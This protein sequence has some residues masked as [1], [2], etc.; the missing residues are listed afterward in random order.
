MKKILLT[1]ISAVR[2]LR[3]VV[4]WAIA[5]QARAQAPEV[6]MHSGLPA[7]AGVSQI[8]HG[9]GIFIANLYG[10]FYSSSNGVDWTQ[11]AG[12]TLHGNWLKTPTLAFGAGKFVCVGDSG[13]IATSRDGQVWT[14]RSSGTTAYL[15]DVKFLHG[16][17]YI[18]G[19]SATFLQSRNGLRW[20]SVSIGKGSATDIYSTVDYG[21]GYFIVNSISPNS[22]VFRSGLD[23]LGN[24]T[25][26]TLTIA[27]MV[28]FLKRYFY[29]IADTYIATSTDAATWTKIPYFAS[30]TRRVS[31]GFYDSSNVYLVSSDYG[32]YAASY[33]Y[34]YPSP[35]GLNFSTPI[36][37][38]LHLRG[39]LYAR[40]HDY[41]FTDKGVLRSQDGV[42]YS[43]LGM[44]FQGVAFHK[45]VAVGVGYMGHWGLIRRTTDY[46]TWRDETPDSASPLTGCV[47]NGSRFVTSGT[48][49]ANNGG[50][51]DPAIVFASPH[52]VNWTS[53][54][55]S[56]IPLSSLTYGTGEG[57]GWYSALGGAG[58][59]SSTDAVSWTLTYA[60]GNIYV[61]KIRYVNGLFYAIGMQ[62]NNAYLP[63]LL[64]SYNG[65]AWGDISPNLPF[66]V[67]SLDDL[68]YDGS[69][70]IL[71]GTQLDSNDF[72]P[73]G[74]FSVK[75]ARVNNPDEWGD[76]GGISSPPAG[77]ILADPEGDQTFAYANGHYVGGAYA[78]KGRPE[79]YLLY[80]NDAVH[81]DYRPLGVNTGI[82]AIDTT[83]RSFH[84]VGVGNYWL[85]VDFARH[86]KHGS[87]D[88]SASLAAS[89][90][91][92]QDPRF[93]IYP[94][95]AAG[96]TTIVLPEQGAAALVL[97][98]VSG[99]A[100]MKKEFNDIRVTLPLALLPAGVYNLTV[101]QNGKLYTGEILHR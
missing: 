69:N 49:G 84:M 39:G 23:T 73:V 31:G 26:D 2:L 52:G 68:I 92:P 48:S 16:A 86:G 15:R 95:P 28:F 30:D 36:N 10:Y 88:S 47:Y 72:Y 7:N 58:I 4:F 83:G 8:V 44:N 22:V 65:A 51:I 21:N 79:S 34:V 50:V 24:W 94:N 77:N 63:L 91:A 75:N 33:G 37:I 60:P 20:H 32:A 17:F 97:Y 11:V 85:T 61:N 81:W 25:A 45:G 38:N 89:A 56:N 64:V 93:R 100:V 46:V 98:D 14:E 90:A 35:D 53:L 96:S 42:H 3:V 67:G 80:S 55:H 59:Y 76:K 78:M 71:T 74:F 1:R 82:V 13:A 62:Q 70:Y 101:H 18:V 6:V 40:Q 66:N 9:N 87:A 99:L 43:P 12:P 57:S 5:N 19:D 27:P 41:I 29:W 54:G